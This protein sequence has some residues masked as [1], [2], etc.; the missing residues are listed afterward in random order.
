MGLAVAG[1]AIIAAG[2]WLPWHSPL[3]DPDPDPVAT[4]EIAGVAIASLLW[5]AAALW[6][7][8][9]GRSRR[10]WLV[11]FAMVPAGWVWAIG[12]AATPLAYSIGDT[13]WA[14]GVPFAIHMLI[15]FPNGRLE[16]RIDRWVVA[17][18]YVLFI[19]G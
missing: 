5:L 8:A 12:Y 14:L 11:L 2:V 4:L 7:R 18:L 19:G 1:L 10:L 15:A 9:K 17:L 3:P 16:G 6:F 13:F